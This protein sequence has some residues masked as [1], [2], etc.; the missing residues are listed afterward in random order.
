MSVE[1]SS[2]LESCEGEYIISVKLSSPAVVW[3]EV[4]ALRFRD[5]EAGA[6]RSTSLSRNIRIPREALLGV[7]EYTVCAKAVSDMNERG[8]V[9]GNLEK[10]V[11]SF[12]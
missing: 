12:P 5:E 10:K 8:V 7:A 2:S 3:V 1:F 6:L 9:L 11:Y 4:G